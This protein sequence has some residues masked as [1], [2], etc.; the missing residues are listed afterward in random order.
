[1]KIVEYR[2]TGEKNN[3]LY[4]FTTIQDI[5]KMDRYKLQRDLKRVSGT[6]YMKYKNQYLYKK[7][8][9]FQLMEETLWNRLDKNEQIEN[10][11]SKN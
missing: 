9:L 2:I 7:E 1:M 8:T 4:D 10:G 3:P 11:L 5:L 6:T